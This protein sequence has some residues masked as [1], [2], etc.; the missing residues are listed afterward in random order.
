MLHVILLHENEIMHNITP[1]RTINCVGKS[2]QMSL[3]YAI[4]RK[5][6]NMVDQ[7]IA[8]HIDVNEVILNH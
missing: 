5:I 2:N 8:M 1:T 7:I 6:Y 4:K 3:C